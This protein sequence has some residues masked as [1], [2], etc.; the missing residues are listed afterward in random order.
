MLSQ[1]DLT[2]LTI[3]QKDGGERGVDSDIE[4]GLCIQ[5]QC[6]KLGRDRQV[7]IRNIPVHVHMKRHVGKYKRINSKIK[8]SATNQQWLVNV[9]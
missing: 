8:F 5:V 2:S 3:R 7:K 1:A 4:G 9:A 6:E